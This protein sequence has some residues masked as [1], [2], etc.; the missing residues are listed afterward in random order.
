MAAAL[1]WS[2]HRMVAMLAGLVTLSGAVTAPSWDHGNQEERDI[3]Q[4][5]I[6]HQGS[7]PWV[8][9][10]TVLSPNCNAAPNE[11][12]L[13]GWISTSVRGLN[14]TVTSVLLVIC[15][16]MEYTFYSASLVLPGHSPCIL[17][18]R[19]SVWACMQHFVSCSSNRAPPSNAEVAVCAQQ[20]W[21]CL[22]RATDHMLQCFE[23]CCLISAVLLHSGCME[24]I[25]KGNCSC[26]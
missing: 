2:H 7:L 11:I 12:I 18:E 25:C 22:K 13:S 23:T 24:C 1:W 3:V 5:C 20:Y 10:H 8:L 17:L 9:P 15:V 19:T 4:K 26:L 6:S 21:R 14:S 16:C